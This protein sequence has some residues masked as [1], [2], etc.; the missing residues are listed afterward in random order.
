MKIL[1][2]AIGITGKS[3]LRRKL[4]GLLK[5]SGL[6]AAH[7]DADEFKELRD[8]A[9]KDCLKK[10]PENFLKETM[11]VIE[12][13]HAPLKSA[14][15]PLESYDFILYVEAGFFSHLLFWLPRIIIWFKQGKFSWEQKQGWKGKG[16]PKDLRNIIP[17]L[18]DF[19]R[20]LKN[21]RKWIREDLERI[22]PHPH[23]IIQSIWT[24]KGPKFRLN[25]T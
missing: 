4:V 19:F 17:I 25:L 3:S 16:K 8:P 7:Y 12:D 22:E 2:T 5:N 11:Y 6:S 23:I 21:R 24:R 20:N 9:D 18:K 14:I 15:L 13:I 1:I 10:L